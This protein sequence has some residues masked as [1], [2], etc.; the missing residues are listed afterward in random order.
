MYNF[1]YGNM[2]FPNMNQ[3]YGQPNV[4]QMQN[5]SPKTNKILVVSLEDALNRYAEPNS[6]MIYIN[7]D[8][9]LLYQVHTDYMGKKTYLIMDLVEHKATS[10]QSN[11]DYVT[12]ADVEKIVKEQIE[13]MKNGEAI[14]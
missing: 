9:P 8:Q 10:T 4:S 2:P 1:N 13:A 12:K 6:E 14:E 11:T 7:Q 3:P 5:A